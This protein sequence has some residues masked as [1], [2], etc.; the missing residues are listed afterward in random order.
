ATIRGNLSVQLE[1][2]RM[3]EKR[4]KALHNTEMKIFVPPVSELEV[5]G[6][7]KSLVLVAIGP[8]IGLILAFAFSLLTESLDH[9]LRTPIEVERFLGKPVLAVLPRLDTGKEAANA[10]RLE[11]TQSSGYI[12]S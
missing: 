5:A 6:G 3:D 7:A 12:S 2:A 4:D 8:I 9:T 10:R 1:Q 11:G